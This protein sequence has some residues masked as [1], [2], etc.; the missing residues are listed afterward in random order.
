MRLKQL[1]LSGFKS[2]AHKTTF[3][4]DSPITSIVGPNGSGKSNCAEAFRWVLGERSMK[5]LRGARGEDLI[6]NGGGGNAS[7]M[8]RA[9]VTLVFDNHDRKFNVDFDEVSITREVYRDGTNVYLINGSQVRF[10]DII[11]LLAAVSLGSSDHYIVNQ[12]DADRIL[13]ANA[14][15][16]RV[17]IE[18]ALGLRLYQWK[19]EESEKKLER[20]EENLKQVESLR[21]ELAPHL[22]FLKKQM[23]K[24]EQAD[25]LRLELKQLYL[26][27]LQREEEYLARETLVLRDERERPTAELADIDRKLGELGQHHNGESWEE[28]TQLQEIDKELRQLAGRRDELGRR[29]GRLEGMQEIKEAAAKARAEEL[30]RDYSFSEVATFT[31]TLK[32][33]VDQAERLFDVGSVKGFLTRIKSAIAEFLEH[34]RSREADQS[35]ETELAGIHEEKARVEAELETVGERERVL[36]LERSDLAVK[37]AE[38]VKQAREAE[39][40]TYELRARRSELAARL[41]TLAARENTLKIE[42]ENFKREL[43]EAKVLVDTEVVR[44][45][46]LGLTLVADNDRSAQEERRRKIERAKIRLEDLGIE[47]TDTVKE[48][49]EA[50]ERDVFLAKEISDLEASGVALKEIIKDLQHKI[51]S[52]FK[53]GIHKIN[54]HFQEFFALMFG[55]G[56]AGLSLIAEKNRRGGEADAD[57]EEAQLGR[58]MRELGEPQEPAKEGIEIKVNLPRKK[59][60]ALEMLSGG[61]RALTSIALLFA[62]SQVNPPPFLILDETDAALDEANSKKYGEMVANLAN[63]SQLILITHNRETMSHAGVIYGVTMSND[64]VSKLL[65]I[66]FDEAAVFAK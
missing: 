10:R 21:R 17:M 47:S 8:N 65:S 3:L 14:S 29:L 5:S 54:T 66:K 37:M 40:E 30:V 2:F 9:A 58:A 12:G 59:I 55:G 34:G 41:G 13:S 38:R 43:D 22:R 49:H 33:Y 42:T 48:Y 23:E 63:H 52:E 7:K 61:E 45:R 53:D 25:A 28:Q 39:R 44:Y 35:A 1:E 24:I 26:E 18:D 50:T 57:D 32:S 19:I 56:T 6:F 51:D 15:E 11:E 27:Y 64:G 62:M 4:F 46:E 20:T 36:Q 16:R 60:R 31:E